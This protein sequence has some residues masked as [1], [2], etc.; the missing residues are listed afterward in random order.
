M[1]N[2]AVELPRRDLL[3]HIGR[4]GQL[5]HKWPLPTRYL[6]DSVLSHDGLLH[7]VD[8]ASGLVFSG[9]R[10]TFPILSLASSPLDMPLNRSSKL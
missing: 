7:S 10:T 3:L 4:E 1:V 6:H 9:F 2:L 5:H 8:T